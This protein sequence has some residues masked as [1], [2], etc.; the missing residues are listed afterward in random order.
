MSKKKIVVTVS[1]ELYERISKLAE[2][3]YLPKSTVCL[4]FI[5]QGLYYND[6]LSLLIS[7]LYI[8]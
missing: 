1:E 2:E 8:K 6:K 3:M 4:N 5:S 7:S